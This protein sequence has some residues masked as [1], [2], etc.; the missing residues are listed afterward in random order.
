M[1]FQNFLDGSP[2]LDIL[3]RD[4]LTKFSMDFQNFLDGSPELLTEFPM[5]FRTFLI[6]VQSSEVQTSRHLIEKLLDG[7]PHGFLKLS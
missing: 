6:E 4:F 1:D 3:S 2:E 5:D 7:I